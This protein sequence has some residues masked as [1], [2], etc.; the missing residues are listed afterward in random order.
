MKRDI[1]KLIAQMTLEEK[2]GMCSGANFWETKAVDRLGIPSIMMSDGPHGLRKQSES[3]DHMGLNASIPATCFPPESALACSWDRSLMEKIGAAIGEECQAENISIILG[4]GSNIKRSPLGGRNFEYLSE[5]PYMS[6]EM[7]A[8]HIRGVQS[9]GVGTSLKHF[10]ANNQEYNRLLIDTIVDERT[11]REIY[12]A[13]FEG[14]VKK[15]QPWTVMC[16]YNKV[17]GEF[18]SE[19]RH[20]LTEILKDEWG[21]EGFVVSDW[22]AVNDRAD[23]LAAGMELEMPTS[24]GF[25]DKRIVDAV[26]G[27]KIPEAALDNAVERILGIVFKAVDNK[28]SN[29]SYSKEEHHQ[30][31]RK[32]EAECM[33]LLKNEDGILPLKKEG[34]LAVIGGFAK[35]PRY[36]GGGSS[37]INPTKIDIPVTEMEK[38]AGSNMK[39]LYADGYKLDNDGGLFSPKVF[40]SESDVADSDLINEAV[41]IAAKSDVAVIFAGLPESYESEGY[42]RQHMKLSEGH[43]K[44]IEA[45]A[46]VQKNVVVVLSNGSPVEMP[47]LSQV[48]GLLEGY[49]GGQAFGGAVADLLFGHANPCGKLAETFPMKLSDNPSYLNFHG[50]PKKVEY[51]E[52]LFVGYRY[53]DAKEIEP[54]FPFGYGLSYTT[55]EHTEIA[56]DKTEIYDDETVGVHVRVRNTGKVN[57][58]ETVQLYVRDVQSSVIRPYRELKGFEKIDLAPGEEK[59]VNF[60]LDK[61]SFAFYDI[62]KRDWRVESG[63]FEILAGSS[64]KNLALKTTIKVQNRTA[65]KIQFTRNTSISDL[66]KV[67]EG[68]QL[69]KELFSDFPMFSFDSLSGGMAEMI[70]SM[71]LRSISLFNPA[72][73]GEKVDKMLEKLNRI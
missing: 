36:Q 63:E 54:L 65:D 41:A 29:A 48:K 33:V 15:A 19:H 71:P 70:M 67:P 39:I 51:R 46:K 49:L 9:R 58:K 43:N 14:A 42:D 50:D 40:T 3:P 21:H 6:S 26:K 16:A 62:E 56:A 66:M 37:H 69:L 24:G 20:L 17:N 34:T 59:T 31:A 38:I 72:G 27:G 28:K 47:W 53:Y 64:S 23:G 30:L 55:F 2:A 1:K 68:A 57:G 5:D 12:L 11:L 25:G 45:V 52:G 13:S 8:G 73:A 18:C 61:R 32:A 7:A 10:A 60:M 44:L 22:G 4:P 35:K